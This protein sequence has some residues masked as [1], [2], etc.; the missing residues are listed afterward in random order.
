MKFWIAIVALVLVI[1]GYG[2]FAT[3]PK[4]TDQQQIQVAIKDS[5]AA[6]KKGQAGGVLEK[7]S[8]AFEINGAKPQMKQVADT[9]RKVKPD[10]DVLQ[11]GAAIEGDQATVLSPV[12]L[13]ANFLGQAVDVTIPNVQL[14]FEKEDGHAWLIFPVHSW[15]LKSVQL[16]PDV[17]SNFQSLGF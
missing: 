1:F 14:Q 3:R 15:R 7:M 11:S 2:Y 6:S 12:H 10:I 4:G 5:I 13:S 9:I 17:L 8:D 16:P